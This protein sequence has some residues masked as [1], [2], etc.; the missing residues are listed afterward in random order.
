MVERKQEKSAFALPGLFGDMV[1]PA[2][3][4]K[5]T[6]GRACWRAHA[7]GSACLRGLVRAHATEKRDDECWAKIGGKAGELK[8]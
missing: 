8:G 3:P 4:R 6:T 1:E 7:C 5:M 2:N